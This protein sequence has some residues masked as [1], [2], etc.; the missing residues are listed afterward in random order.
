MKRKWGNQSIN[1]GYVPVNNL[2]LSV[3]L[4]TLPFSLSVPI[5]VSNEY[6]PLCS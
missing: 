6:T 4:L 1:L 5:A 3:Y 2:L